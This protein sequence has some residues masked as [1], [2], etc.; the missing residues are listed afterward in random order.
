MSDIYVRSTDGSDADDGSTWALAKAKGAGAAAIDAAGDRILFSHV[1]SETTAGNVLLTT[2]GTAAAPVQVLCANDSAEPPTAL[3]T[4][5]AIACTGAASITIAGW[6]YVYGLNLSAGSGA[7]TANIFLASEAAAVK[8]AYRE[9][10][11]KL[12]NTSFS[13]VIVLGSSNSGPKH[14]TWENCEISFSHAA[15]A[16]TVGDLD[17]TW[18]GGGAVSGTTTPS[19]LFTIGISGRSG[20]VLCEGVDFSNFSSSLNLVSTLSLQ[21]KSVFRSCKLPASWSGGLFGFGTVTPGVRVEMH[22]CDNAD[23]NYRLWVQDFTGSIKSE[24]TVIRTGGANDGT[25]GLSWIMA[26]SADAE[27]PLNILRAPEIVIWND[28][29]GSAITVTIEVVTDNVTLTDAEAWI[30]AQYLGT[31]GFPLGSFI[32]DAK[33]D[34]LA[35]AAN[36]TSSSETWTT[37]GLTTPVKQKLSVTFTPQEKGFI[38]I[39]PC[40]AKAST[41]MYVCP[42]PDVT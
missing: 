8:Q 21:C 9:C 38:H 28:T 17:F 35:S 30:E 20:S 32:D 12:T 23:T 2:A 4:T 24:T 22:N 29:T 26:S 42:K 3:A 41:T 40:L 31:S 19:A 14:I 25:T 1:H 10:T 13:S 11:F 15:Q 37:T 27:Y 34:V 5:A 16:I 18:R 7:T 33:A 39:T 6:A 36:Q